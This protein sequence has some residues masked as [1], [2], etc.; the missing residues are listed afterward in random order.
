VCHI[1]LHGPIW[2][3][4][5]S[6]CSIVLLWATLWV[7]APRCFTHKMKTKRSQMYLFSGCSSFHVWLK[8]QWGSCLTLY[9]RRK[10]KYTINK[11]DMASKLTG[12][13][14]RCERN[15]GW[16]SLTEW[17]HS[18]R[19]GGMPL[20][21]QELLR[22]LVVSLCFWHAVNYRDSCRTTLQV[23]PLP[24]SLFSFSIILNWFCFSIKTYFKKK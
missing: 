12:V 19:M 8:R 17:L 5:K 10:H 9:L 3:Q 16:V 6:L 18:R 15:G 13:A 24:P 22:L 20:H 11:M 2:F 21:S 23:S 1:F 7:T 14:V 4:K